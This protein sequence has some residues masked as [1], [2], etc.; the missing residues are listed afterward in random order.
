MAEAK[1]PGRDV[2]YLD[3][4]DDISTIIDKVEASKDKVVALVLPKR[5]ATMQ[6]IV[7]MRLLRRSADKATKNLVLVTNEQALMPLAGAAGLHV[8]KNLQSAPEVPSSPV[9]MPEPKPNLSDDPDSEIDPDDA[10]L[11]YHRSIGV[12]AAAK[13]VDEPETIP[14]EDAEDDE[15]PKAESKQPKK[16]KDKKNKVPN[17]E[18]FR[19]R[20]SLGLLGAGALVAFLI[21]AI[22]VL[23][24]ATITLTTEATPISAD[25]ELL[26]SGS[27]DSLNTEK[28]IIPAE[29][30]S[31]DIKSEDNVQA[32]GQKNN[33]DK[34]SG[35]VTMSVQDCVPFGSAPSSVPSGTGIN[36]GGNYYIT[37]ATANFG[38]PSP[39]SPSCITYHSN[40][41]AIIAQAAGEKYNVSGAS[42]TVPNRSDVNGSGS[43]SGGT[44]DIES[45][46]S[47]SDID[48]VANKI[49]DADK[50]EFV[51]KFKKDLDE[52][53]LYIIEDTLKEKKPVIS[54]SPAVGQPASTANVTVKITY[55]VLTVK[56]SDLEKAV[57]AELNKQID[58]DKQ[59][60][61]TDDVLKDI[62][63]SV[64]KQSSSTNA[65]LSISQDTTAVPVLD[66]AA[67]KKL[68]AGQKE[69]EIK[70]VLESY[71]GVKSVEVDMSPFWVSKA[72]KKPEKITIVQKQVSTEANGS[73][74]NSS[75]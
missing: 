57:T 60:I 25:F 20:M 63:V 72:P 42:F 43:A 27:A 52:Q 15:K 50:K 38:S 3:V 28:G 53:G 45:I 58:P 18:R 30:K 70:T 4:D 67:I 17:F 36:S 19:N 54:S 75:P 51:D 71:P 48:K 44:D 62:S 47:Q 24:K 64:K 37:Q 66:E 65:L 59:K 14:L 26:A 13:A 73:S 12:L 22:F 55:S 8:A 31:D 61:G 10:K 9:D 49:S 35:S 34:A 6:S 69:G 5:F 29:L 2:I 41:V 1:K 7:N 68:A 21:L 40:T 39:S 74:G 11:D 33:G 16:P 32:T 56:K 46:L 23:P